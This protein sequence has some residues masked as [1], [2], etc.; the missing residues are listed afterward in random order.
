MTAYAA[1]LV[2]DLRATL[3]PHADPARATS[4]AAYLKT[5]M[6][7]LGVSRPDQKR[8]FR[9]V[10]ARH[11]TKDPAEWESA[12]RLAWAGPE[13]ELKYAAIALLLAFRKRFLTMA[14]VPLLEQ[15]AREGAWWD[16]VDEI[17]AHAVGEVVA[18]HRDEM[19]PVLVRWIEDPDLWVR[20]TALLA[21]LR[22]RR[23]T[24]T[25]LLFDFCSR[26]AADKSFWIR[27][28]VGWAL[29]AHAHTDPD[30]VRA[31]LAAHG[32]ALS[33]LSRREASKHL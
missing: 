18:R 15:L 20:R 21:Q 4:M 24:D 5:D 29:R 6:P 32:E 17:A 11:P 26:Q 27:K 9:E 2:A 31:Y 22:H 12:V 30:A 23:D 16:L 7:M 1:D 19:R 8:V 28:A 33:G 3:A 25:E 10:F 13:R 14:A